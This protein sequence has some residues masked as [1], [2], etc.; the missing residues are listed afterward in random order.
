MSG[1]LIH[2]D[3]GAEIFHNSECSFP[4]LRSAKKVAAETYA[5]GN[6]VAVCVGSQTDLGARQSR[7]SD[8]MSLDPCCFKGEAVSQLDAQPSETSQSSLL[9]SQASS[10]V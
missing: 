4:F 3:V 9:L 6:S 10:D 7:I 1:T 5:Q 2:F 8:L